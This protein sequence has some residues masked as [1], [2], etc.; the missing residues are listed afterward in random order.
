MSVAVVEHACGDVRKGQYLVP[1]EAREGVAGK[2]LGYDVY[3]VE[4]DGVKGSLVLLQAN[5]KQLG[6]NHWAII[7]LGADQGIQ[8]G[9]QLVLYRRMR[10]DQPVQILGNC[11]VID[12]QSSTSTV[13]ILSCRDIIQ[14]GDLVMERPS[15]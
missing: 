1:F 7:D 10:A 9:Q 13:K 11:V 8:V 14:K 3:P 15:R 4:G 6:S 12:V 2:D 5:L